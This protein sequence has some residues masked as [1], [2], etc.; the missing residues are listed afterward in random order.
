MTQ[1]RSVCLLAPGSAPEVQVVSPCPSVAININGND[2]RCYKHVVGG[3][4]GKLCKM[5]SMVTMHMN[6]EHVVAIPAS[7][8]VAPKDFDQCNYVLPL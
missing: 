7:I 6:N 3:G 4:H 2:I 1:P 8:P 5:S